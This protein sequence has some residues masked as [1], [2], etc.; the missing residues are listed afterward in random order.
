MP[1]GRLNCCLTYLLLF[2]SFS[3]S[4][5]LFSSPSLFTLSLHPPFT[6]ALYLSFSILSTSSTFCSYLLHTRSTW[7]TSRVLELT[8]NHIAFPPKLPGTR[9]AKVEVVE[10]DILT[11]LRTAVH[12]TKAYSS[13]NDATSV[14]EGLEES[15]EICQFVN[16]NSFIN[17]EAM[18]STLLS[19][20]P[21]HT[22]I[23]HVTQQNAGLIIRS[24]ESDF[25]FEAF[26]ASP[27]AEKTL[28]AKG[29]M[30]WD[31]PTVA[32]SLP[33]QDFESPQFQENLTNFLERASLDSID[34]FAAK[35][36][37]AGVAITEARDTSH[38]AL[39]T[40]F[41]MTLLEVNGARA[42]VPLLR[43]RVKRRHCVQASLSPEL[44]NFLRA[45]LCR[46]LAKLE[47]EKLHGSPS[48]IHTYSEL[49]EN[50][51]PICHKAIDTT[52]T[53]IEKQWA[54]FKA[55][56]LRKIP[57]LPRF[58]DEDDLHLTLPNSGSYLR[59]VLKQSY[60]PPSATSPI[61]DAATLGSSTSKS[62]T[63][64]YSSLLA[65]YNKLHDWE[66]QFETTTADIPQS[67]SECSK[68]CQNLAKHIHSYL[69]AVEDAYDGNSEQ[70]S[71]LILNILETWV[72]MDQCAVKVHP[73]LS[74]Y[75]PFFEPGMLDVLL[76]TRLSDM[77]RLQAIQE[78][79]SK[80]CTQAERS[81]DIFADPQ[82]GC[83]AD[84]IFTL[85]ETGTVAKL[86][87]LRVSI[88]AASRRSSTADYGDISKK[89]FF[90][91]FKL[92]YR[93]HDRLLVPS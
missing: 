10:K 23:L 67:Q 76:L 63:E 66:S 62:T 64:F 70:M 59:G 44:C 91:S 13:D 48:V 74:Q 29:A 47:T 33:R 30:Q 21:H 68:K 26:E 36:H 38:P 83:F 4:L 31:F 40:D 89:R 55:R 73:L 78:Y 3:L 22:L 85:G 42:N 7:Q 71:I 43:K 16:E 17:R 60:H 20:K 37:K 82:E 92:V 46:R 50:I 52:T 69:E 49:F 2:L 11:R 54:T 24:S 58:A 41:L 87:N 57:F 18:E 93:L 75:H 1:V 88:E 35:T 79:I 15:L 8:F 28:A 45:K 77:K 84:Q 27:S 32:V 9:D 14:W 39:V 51:G 81:L 53:F 12:I 5:S 65:R 72:Y 6:L 86:N 56:S 90:F 34:E 19:I 25:I 61:I 80:R